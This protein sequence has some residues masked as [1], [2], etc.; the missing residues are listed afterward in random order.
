MK[1]RSGAPLVGI[2]FLSFVA[3]G[4][5][6][7]LL[8][9]A[10]P[11]IRASF[12]LSLDAIGMLLLASTIGYLLSSFSSGPLIS[13]MGVG[14]FLMASHLV[15]G[16]GLLG[17]ALA[18]SWW[19]M[20]GCGLLAG[21]GTGGTDAGLNTYFAANHSASL[22]NWLH[23]CFGLGAALGPAVMALILDAGYAWRW[24]YALVVALAGLLAGLFALTLR[25]WKLAEPETALTTSPTPAQAGLLDT[26][27]L[28]M[29]WLGIALFVIFT[30][31]EAS[32]GQWPYTLFTEGR[33]VDPRIAGLWVSIYWGSLTVGRILFGV[34]VQRVGLLTI[35]R[36]CMLGAIC[37]P[38]LIWWNPAN[39]V[40]YL[41]L[42]LVGF[43]LA[44]IF[45]LL[46]S[47][48]P[49]RL[50]SRHAANAIG[51]QVAAASIGL[52]VLPGLAG[53]LAENLGLETIGPF[54]LV[55]AIAMFVLHESTIPRGSRRRSHELASAGTSL[56]D[57]PDAAQ[58]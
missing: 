34:L 47:A 49:A 6:G 29:V 12:G 10:W 35:V 58:R 3:L 33:G 57:T 21:L 43:C 40:S 13:A 42:A 52:G 45:P 51:L 4:V 15:G 36:L 44:P 27:R 41:G 16:L 11:S 20:V 9:V 1:P 22:M 7:G 19:A 26:L 25:Q 17:Y 53:V 32:G 2:A 38:A 28:P 56:V 46:I 18:P 8:G 24:G 37:G 30:G 55:V 5:P 48:T 23:A 31:L 50:G 14:S 54:L 39:L